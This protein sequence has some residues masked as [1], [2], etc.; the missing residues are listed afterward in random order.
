MWKIETQAK[1]TFDEPLYTGDEQYTVISDLHLLDGSKADNSI[2]ATEALVNVLMKTKL[3]G[4]KLVLNGDI[5]EGWQIDGPD[6]L[7]RIATFNQQILFRMRSILDTWVVGNHDHI[8]LTMVARQI[9]GHALGLV[10]VRADQVNVSWIKGKVYI[11]HGHQVDPFNSDEGMW[12]GRF[13]SGIW[14]ALERV[15]PKKAA[16]SRFRSFERVLQTQKKLMNCGSAA[17]KAAAGRL[18]PKLYDNRAEEIRR[19]RKNIRL[20]IYGH[21][22]KASLRVLPHVWGER[23]MTIVNGGCFVDERKEYSFVE[24]DSNEVRLMQWIMT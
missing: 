14:G 23:Q 2:P 4:R 24:I 18:D 3:E 6:G 10:P 11:E 8:V 9:M 13:L 22:H 20:Y 16:T 21:T 17:V 19:L 5:I 15:L 12:I 7:A 1:H